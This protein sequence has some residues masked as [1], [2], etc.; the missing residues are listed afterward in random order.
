MSAIRTLLVLLSLPALA[1]AQQQISPLC[2]FDYNWQNGVWDVAQSGQYAYLARGADGLS[3]ADI[4]NPAE[5]VI[6]ADIDGDYWGDM[7]LI[8]DV[9]LAMNGEGI[10]LYRTSA[11]QPQLEHISTLS[12]VDYCSY[13]DVCGTRAVF[14][15]RTGSYPN[16]HTAMVLLDLTNPEEPV[17]LARYE[18]LIS[19]CSD[20]CLQEDR[21]LMADAVPGMIWVDISD[22][23]NP[24]VSEPYYDEY[25]NWSFG[26]DAFGDYA[27]LAAGGSGFQLIDLQTMQ[28]VASLPEYYYAF[29]IQ[30][31]GDIAFMSYGD[32]DCPLV[33]IDLSDPLEPVA[34]GIY[35]PVVDME[36]FVIKGNKAYC[37]CFQAGLRVVELSDPDN[38]HELGWVGYSGRL[39]DIARSGDYALTLEDMGLRVIDISDPTAPELAGF[40]EIEQAYDIEMLSEDIAIVKT[41]AAENLITVDLSNPLAP[42]ILGVGISEHMP[43]S[44][45]TL[46]GNT[47]VLGGRNVIHFLDVSDPSEIVPLPNMACQSNSQR[48]VVWN[49]YLIHSN[50]GTNVYEVLEQ[51]EDEILQVTSFNAQYPVRLRLAGDMLYS[52]NSNGIRVMDLSLLPDAPIEYELDLIGEQEYLADI[53]GRDNLLFVAS[54][55]DS[56]EPTTYIRVYDNT[57]PLTPQLLAVGTTPGQAEEMALDEDLMLLANYY[58]LCIYAAT[59]IELS[60]EAPAVGPDG[61][62]LQGCYPNPFNPSTTLQFNCPRAAHVKLGVYNLLGKCITT[63]ADR[64]FSAGEH[65]V[66]WNGQSSSGLGVAS[67]SYF[68]VAEFPDGMRVTSVSLQK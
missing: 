44:D 66:S 15:G 51:V 50:S 21:I 53:K 58:D 49:D 8:G 48:Y 28:S 62:A 31:V 26:I 68:I 3:I 36:N 52:S 34:R 16:F 10:G 25:A 29:Q 23:E 38:L 35:E 43:S 19:G 18:D 6:V 41:Y 14:Y 11:S 46:W 67:G 39:C 4:S 40:L 2:Q 64:E 17:E 1:L 27:C 54:V 59:E 57:D 56:F 47:V 5:P 22:L 12:P 7:A 65:H 9:M 33:A 20:I 32:I 42:C 45:M 37:A 55:E 61:F 24:V 13:M 63:L 30:V 60:V